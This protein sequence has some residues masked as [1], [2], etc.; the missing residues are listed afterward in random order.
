MTPSFIAWAGRQ[1]RPI[2]DWHNERRLARLC[3]DIAAARAE[4]RTARRQ[5]KAVRPALKALSDA[6]HAELRREVHHG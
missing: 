3:P 1:L 6:V 2:M 4:V 5:H